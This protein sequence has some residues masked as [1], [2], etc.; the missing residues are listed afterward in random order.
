MPIANFFRIAAAL[1]TLLLLSSQVQASPVVTY[2]WTTTNQGYGRHIDQPTAATF[3]V[4]LSAV[5][6]GKI[7]PF[8]I[9]NIQFTYPGLSFNNSAVSIVGFDF[10]A[11]VDPVTGALKYVDIQQGLAIIAFAGA[12]INDATTFL[13][14]TFGNPESGQVRDRFNAL[15]NAASYAGFPTAGYW[16]ASF[17]PAAPGDVPEPG[18]LALL[19]LGLLGAMAVRRRNHAPGR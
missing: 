5:Q 2:S 13:S 15:K 8:D 3:D 11:Y 19:G 7:S 6:S 16:N 14:I 9:S 17:A 4:S 18:S 10:G 12:S 1:L